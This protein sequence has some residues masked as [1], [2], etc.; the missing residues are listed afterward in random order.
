MLS[1]TIL[2]TDANTFMK[3]IHNRM[4]VIL[5][6]D[7]IPDWLDQGSQDIL[8]PCNDELLT[9]Y[10]VDKSVGNVKNNSAELLEPV[11]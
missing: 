3:D 1:C 8:K 7:Q 5:T 4:P 2:T 9:A 11:G 10:P 6:P